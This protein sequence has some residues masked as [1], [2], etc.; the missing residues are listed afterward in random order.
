MTRLLDLLAMILTVLGLVALATAG[1]HGRA[2]AAVPFM[3]DMWLAAGLLRLG[4]SPS[5]T[6]ASAAAAILIIRRLILSATSPTD[7]C[8]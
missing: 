4:G 3:L 6:R 5:W 1:W 7:R 8:S 2:R